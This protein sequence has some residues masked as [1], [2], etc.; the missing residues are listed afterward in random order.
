[1]N[2]L[3][4]FERSGIV[5]EAFRV[6]GHNAW[7]CD[8]EASEDNSYYHFR[9]DSLEC[10]KGSHWD[11]IIAH[12]PCQYLCS[13]GLHWNKRTPGRAEKTEAALRLF[14]EAYFAATLKSRA[15]FENPV[16]CVS[17]RFRKP[18]QYIQP[19]D[20]GHDASKKTGLWLHGLPLLKPTKYIEPRIVDGKKR[21]GNQT[22]SG[23]NRLGPSDARSM[24]RA[25]TYTGIANAMAE[26][27][28]Y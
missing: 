12:P 21:W 18:D 2:V 9:M 8:L 7:S 17:S 4:A 1:M 15:A 26:Q 20:F 19:Y 27:W 23:Q 10:I 22:D 24:E 14:T 6:R 11:L 5:R 16:G 28:G 25:R 3:V 13:S